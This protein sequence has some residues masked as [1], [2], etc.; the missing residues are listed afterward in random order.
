MQPHILTTNISY[1][2]FS[3]FSPLPNAGLPLTNDRT[4]TVDERVPVFGS[5][6]NS[7]YKEILSR[8]KAD[9]NP[10]NK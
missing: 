4:N 1:C 2:I 7:Q 9:Q 6:V 8:I 3:T 10:N 5:A